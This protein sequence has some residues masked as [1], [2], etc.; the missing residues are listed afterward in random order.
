MYFGYT[1]QELAA[2][3][4]LGLIMIWSLW[5]IFNSGRLVSRFRFYFVL[6][7][8]IFTLWA[9][10]SGSAVELYQYLKTELFTPD[11]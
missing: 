3:A 8:A 5:R 4:V 10:R 1:I 6:A 7:A 9:W 2:F 11:F